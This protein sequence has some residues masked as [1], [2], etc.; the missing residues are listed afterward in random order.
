[1]NREGSD[2]QGDDEP[3]DP[4]KRELKKS[5]LSTAKID[6]YLAYPF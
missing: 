5:R 2:G 1:M 4:N 3:E 6:K